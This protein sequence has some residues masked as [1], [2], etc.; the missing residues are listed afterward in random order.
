[1]SLDRDLRD[2]LQPL[3]GDPIADA[4]RVLA[5][6]PPAGPL[7]PDPA[8]PR[9]PLPWWLLLAGVALGAVLGLAGAN[10]FGGAPPATS[11]PPQPAQ[12]PQPAPPPDPAVAK[13]KPDAPPKSRENERPSEYADQLQIMAF[14]ELSI[15]E[16]GVG[17]Q[18]L[19]PGGYMAAVGTLFDTG[20]SM[21]GIYAYAN[22][23]RV[24]LDRATLALV[25]PDLVTLQRGR[26]WLSNATRPAALVVRADRVDVD[27]T[28][29]V[30]ML[31]ARSSGL[32]ACCLEG[33]AL[34]RP[35]GG[36]AFRL[37]AQQQVEIDRRTGRGELQ[38][39]AFAGTLTSWMTRMILQQ[40]DDTELYGRIAQLLD[41]YLEGTHR[42]AAAIELRRLGARAAGKLYGALDGMV[43][44]PELRQRTAALL[45]DVAEYEQRDWLLALL[46]FDDADVRA[47]AFQGLV[48]VTGAGVE[49]EAFWR[50]GDAVA[51]ATALAAW[52]ERL[53]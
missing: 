45:A 17:R 40:T 25:Q 28:A 43:S 5:A 52:R 4:M 22:D 34:V 36:T 18:V 32:W 49:D 14:G 30:L 7:P 24:R 15:D 19:A 21:A 12:P 31:E 23:V 1:M 16:P 41:A 10:W 48:R 2:A 3:A 42:E 44:R 26:L 39:V 9:A 29:A 35:L 33:E 11:P 53:R 6:L 51:R 13:P 47:V 20:P 38:K 27:V 50:E 46:E 37:P 8:P